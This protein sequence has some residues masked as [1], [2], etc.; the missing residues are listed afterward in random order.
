MTI[1][2]CSAACILH[3]PVA[4]EFLEGVFAF[5]V[6]RADAA[7]ALFGRPEFFAN[8]VVGVGDGIDAERARDTA[9]AAVALAILGEVQWDIRNLL[10]LGVLPDVH[11]RPVQQR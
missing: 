6:L 2:S 3:V 10:A 8:L 9:E 7:L 4:A 11:L 5:L 1:L